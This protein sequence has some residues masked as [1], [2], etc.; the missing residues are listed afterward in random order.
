MVAAHGL[1]VLVA[2]S[3]VA[4]AVAAATSAEEE[5]SRGRRGVGAEC[6][7]ASAASAADCFPGKA[8]ASSSP[9]KKSGP[10]RSGEQRA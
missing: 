10:S 1:G 2:A 4:A 8:E 5:T 7:D 9:L 3:L 6:A